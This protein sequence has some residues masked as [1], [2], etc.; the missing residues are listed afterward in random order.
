MILSTWVMNQKRGAWRRLTLSFLEASETLQL[1]SN[2]QESANSSNKYSTIAIS[3][4]SSVAPL[5]RVTHD[6]NPDF[7]TTRPHIIIKSIQRLALE[8]MSLALS[9]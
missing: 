8:G 5:R 6:L 1:L 2:D 7:N 9:I 3:R 4:T